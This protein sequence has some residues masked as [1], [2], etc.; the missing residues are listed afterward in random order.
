MPYF[1]IVLLIVCA[2]F[3]YQ[4]AENEGDSGLLWAALS[5]VISILFLR[6][7]SLGS[8]GILIGQVLFLIG[9][10]VFRALGKS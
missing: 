7:T 2:V 5:V 10:G 8:L 1:P 3:F 6:F 9:I 4:T